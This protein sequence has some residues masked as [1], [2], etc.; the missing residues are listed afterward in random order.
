MTGELVDTQYGP[1][2]VKVT[3]K[4]TK[5]VDLTAVRLPDANQRDRDI[6]SYAAPELRKEALAAQ[7]AQIDSVSGAT[8]TSEG[9]IRSLQSA[10]DQ[11]GV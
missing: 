10:L 1:V 11:A 5:L 2:Q 6:A 7:S 3:L 9:Y 4:G 8:Y